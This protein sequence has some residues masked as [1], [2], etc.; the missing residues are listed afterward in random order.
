[1]EFVNEI[2]ECEREDVAAYVDGE[3]S[4]D[5]L[6]RFEAHVAK[7]SRCAD[8]LRVQRELLCT[9]NSAFGDTGSFAMPRDFTRVVAAH[10]QSDVRRV[11]HKS[12][13]RHTLKL[14][15]ILTLVS[16]ALLGTAWSVIVLEPVR[17]LARVGGSVLELCG[18]TIY[19]AATGVA[20]IIRMLGRALVFDSH[21]FGWLIVLPFV[22]V[23]FLLPV[24]IA[25][26]HRA[27]VIE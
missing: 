2:N 4:G 20:V 21:G 26:Y 23:V 25:N 17:T 24:L 6:E 10:A 22:L 12:E 1:M 18:R 13:R 3:L 27:R 7:C 5:A 19:G 8:E 9:L 16:F 15:I 11:H 14:L